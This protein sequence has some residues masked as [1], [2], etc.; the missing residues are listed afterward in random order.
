MMTENL[1][2]QAST[3][4]APVDPAVITLIGDAS[5]TCLVQ[6]HP[7]LHMVVVGSEAK[8]KP[9]EAPSPPIAIGSAMPGLPAAPYKSRIVG[10]VVIENQGIAALSA[11]LARDSFH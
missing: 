9:A 10:R 2:H 6:G 11:I 4:D 8:L 3:V 7:E 1:Q 5:P